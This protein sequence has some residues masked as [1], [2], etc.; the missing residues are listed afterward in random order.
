MTNRYVVHKH[1]PY[2]IYDNCLGIIIATAH[3]QEEA[4]RICGLLNLQDEA[5]QT[6]RLI[7]TNT[8]NSD[9]S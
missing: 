6:I 3:T 8:C 4:S 7:C 9:R 1:S 5:T 2:A